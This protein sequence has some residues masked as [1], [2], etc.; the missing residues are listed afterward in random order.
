MAANITPT[1]ID[2]IRHGEPVGGKR[3]RGQIDD[4][5]SDK[6]WQQMKDA[7]A[8]HQPWDQIV[9]SPLV[10]CA[11]FATFLSTQ[12]NIPMELDERL[13]EIRWGEWEG[14]RPSEINHKD[15]H[16]VIKHWR[17]PLQKPPKDSESVVDFQKRIIQAWIALEQKYRQQHI[18]VV[19]HAGVIRAVLTHVLQTPPE[20][21]FRIHVTNA[22]ITRIRIDYHD[23]KPFARL[24]FHDGQL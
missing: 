13:M 8:R 18:L 24:L 17:N 1:I 20:H 14:K 9:S 4:P 10:R 15:P 21:M 2:L 22:S 3:Y 7:V 19:C 6:G 11:D 12:H 5:L 23:G 16:K